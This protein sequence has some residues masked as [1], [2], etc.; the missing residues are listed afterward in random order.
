[1]R[2]LVLTGT[3]VQNDLDELFSLVNFTVPGYLGE[4]GWWDSALVV[5]LPIF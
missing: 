4:Q 2:R 5:V 1:M 3:P